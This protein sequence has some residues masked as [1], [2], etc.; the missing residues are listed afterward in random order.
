[1]FFLLGGPIFLRSFMSCVEILDLS[2][3]EIWFFSTSSS[4]PGARFLHCLVRG[5][6]AEARSR[7]RE[8]AED[9]CAECSRR[10]KDRER[11]FAAQRRGEERSRVRSYRGRR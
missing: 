5:A 4:A 8:E 6:M 10:R 7:K 9:V 1:M 3:P 11:S 2:H